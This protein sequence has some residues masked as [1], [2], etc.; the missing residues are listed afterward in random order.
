MVTFADVICALGGESSSVRPLGGVS[1]STSPKPGTVSFIRCWAAD[2]A[3]LLAGNPETLFIVPMDR[4]GTAGDNL[5][6][7]VNPRLAYALAVRDFFQM[8]IPGRFAWPPWRRENGGA[9]VRDAD[10]ALMRAS[11]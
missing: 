7:V 2:N 10:D 5:V 1:S 11:S 6:P 4:A 9:A 8:R 3:L